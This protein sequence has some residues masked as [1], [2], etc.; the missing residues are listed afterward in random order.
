MRLVWYSQPASIRCK[1]L[2]AG[3]LRPQAGL[4]LTEGTSDSRP[5]EHGVADFGPELLKKVDG[6]AQSH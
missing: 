4:L 1:L 3:H 5:A 6:D 2:L